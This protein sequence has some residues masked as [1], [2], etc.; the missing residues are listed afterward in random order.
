MDEPQ[1]HQFDFNNPCHGKWLKAAF[2]ECQ[3]E[4]LPVFEMLDAPTRVPV[5]VYRVSLTCIRCQFKIQ[6]MTLSTKA[7]WDVLNSSPA[8]IQEVQR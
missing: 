5:Y 4:E 7:D 2:R 3:A 8:A 1:V 6:R